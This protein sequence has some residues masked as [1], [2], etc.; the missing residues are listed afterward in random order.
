MTTQNTPPTGPDKDTSTRMCACG[1]LLSGHS[2]SEPYECIECACKNFR[3][4]PTQPEEPSLDELIEAFDKWPVEKGSMSKHIFKERLLTLLEPEKTGHPDRLRTTREHIADD[5]ID[6]IPLLETLS[7]DGR[8]KLVDY[9]MEHDYK[10]WYDGYRQGIEAGHKD[11]VTMLTALLE[12]PSMGYTATEEIK[13]VIDSVKV[14]K[15]QDG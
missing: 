10:D 7:A 15:R 9:I 3:V 12:T 4:P 1:H 5:L 6:L 2:A 8:K 14:A 13:K 11:A